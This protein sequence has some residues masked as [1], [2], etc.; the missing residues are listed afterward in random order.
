[1]KN[2]LIYAAGLL[3][4]SSA[5]A[6]DKP[7]P[8]LVDGLKNPAAL[9]VDLG[10]KVLHVSAG[11]SVLR[12]ENGK[13]VPFASGLDDPKGM[14]SYLQWLFVADRKVV[15]RIDKSGRVDVFTATKAFPMEPESLTGLTADPENGT[16]YVSDCRDAPGNGYAIY[17]ITPLGV[18]S[19][20][21]DSP[22]FPV[23]RKPAALLLDGA[24][25]LLVGDAGSGALYRIKLADGRGGETGFDGLG[26]ASPAWRGTIAMADSSRQ[27]RQRRPTPRPDCVRGLARKL[28]RSGERP[29]L[30]GRDLPGP[31]RQAHPGR[32][33]RDGRRVGR[34]RRR[35]R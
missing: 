14:A 6:A 3:S 2:I 5:A 26:V 35:S 20:L 24:S 4:A 25:H 34:R 29:P 8:S 28:R 23:L 18:V 22:R 32:R 16:L 15:R 30:S 21:L 17:R 1:M 27:R 31:H 12:I 10:G 9:T 13:A 33:P 7:A 19:V 11:N